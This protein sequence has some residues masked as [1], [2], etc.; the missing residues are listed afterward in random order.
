MPLDTFAAET[1]PHLAELRWAARRYAGP[2]AD[3]DLVQET[4]LRAFAARA[5]YQ[6]GTNAR[7]WLYRILTN[8]ARSAYRRGQRERR[9]CDEVARS[10]PDSTPGGQIAEPRLRVAFERL[11]E[12]YRAV[13]ELSDIGGYSYREIADTLGVPIGTVMSRLHR[14]RQRLR[15]ALEGSRSLH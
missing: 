11:P 8:T 9:L 13:V 3:E 1:L 10:T 2:G 4:F 6:P 7:A 14:A 15:A 12:S 5:R